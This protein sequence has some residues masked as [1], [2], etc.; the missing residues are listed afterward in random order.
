MVGGPVSCAT[1]LCGHV[2]QQTLI[3]R[4]VREGL[5]DRAAVVASWES[6]ADAAALQPV[7]FVD[8]GLRDG[9]PAAPWGDARLD[10]GTW[11]KAL[12]ALDTRP[13]FLWISLNDADEW[14]HRG[15]REAY[16]LTL[17]RYDIWLDELIE[18]LRTMDEYGA[19]TTIVV[20]TDHGRGDGD[21]WTSH[22]WQQPSSRTIFAFAL[23]RA[24]TAP[25]A[26]APA[27]YTHRW[28]RPTLEKLLGL[29]VE[30]DVL[31]FAVEPRT[32]PGALSALTP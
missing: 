27:L 1:N 20:T 25:T 10:R 13:R 11:A 31:P 3:D 7:S 12:R 22:G 9:D 6:I 19:N 4:L 30:R 17:R 28:I 16:L 15:R 18:R 21:D 29:S 32:D 2:Q 14:G 8:A 5:G 23:G 26:S 24:V